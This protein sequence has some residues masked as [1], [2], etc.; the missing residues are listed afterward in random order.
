MPSNDLG[1]RDVTVALGAD[2][3]DR[4]R[5]TNVHTQH[6]QENKAEKGA[7]ARPRGKGREDDRVLYTRCAFM[8][9]LSEAV[10]DWNEGNYLGEE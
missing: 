3:L 8:E 6:H 9:G 1:I 10:R 7:R 5:Q 4:D 2:G